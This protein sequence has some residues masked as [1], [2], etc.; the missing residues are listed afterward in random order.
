MLM[1]FGHE[2]LM[3]DRQKQRFIKNVQLLTASADNI[4]SRGSSESAKAL[5]AS[6]LIL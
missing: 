3:I 1:V 5:L 2:S 6:S 4:D